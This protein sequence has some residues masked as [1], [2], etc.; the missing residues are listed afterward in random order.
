M[1][2]RSERTLKLTTTSLAMVA[3]I[4]ACSVFTNN[5]TAVLWTNRP[6]MAAYAELFNAEMDGRR[7]EVVYQV[8]PWRALENDAEHPDLVAGARL[9]SVLSI[10]HFASIDRLISKGSI[11][12]ASFYQ[13]ALSMGRREEKTFLLPLSFS[14]PIVVFRSEFSAS[15]TDDYYIG[16]DEMRKLSGEFN[17]VDGRPTRMGYSP[18]WQPEFVYALALTLG[19]EFEETDE[20]LPEWNDTRIQQT[21]AYAVEWINDTNGGYELENSFETKYM[22]NPLYKLLDTSQILFNFMKISEFLSLPAA[23]RENLDF[24]WFSAGKKI[25][26]CDDVIFVGKTRQSRKIKTTDAFLSWLFKPATQVKL[27]ETAKF[28]RMR[29]FGIAGGLSSLVSVNID[30]LPRFFPFLIGHLPD[31]DLLDFPNRLPEGWEDMRD[32]IIVP[33]L[34]AA[35]SPDADPKPLGEHIRQWRLQQPGLYQ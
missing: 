5:A 12:P 19:A 2:Q 21:I 31:R 13:E 14:L 27:L 32:S 34:S 16:V 24:R 22:Y 29:S 26:V 4:S 9:D 3:M 33:W 10:G 30:A 1:K 28:E 11:N 6:E 15:L 18:R 35:T 20:R 7:I 23:I 8:E 25:S 17:I